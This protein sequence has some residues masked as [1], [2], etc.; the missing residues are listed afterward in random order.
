[1]KQHQNYLIRKN[2]HLEDIELW[3]E[4]FPNFL[5]QRISGENIS[6]EAKER[7]VQRLLQRA[8]LLQDTIK[9][10]LKFQQSL[11]RVKTIL[12]QKLETA[13]QIGTFRVTDKGLAVAKQEG[14]VCIDHIG[15]AVKLVDRLEF[16]RNNWLRRGEENE[17]MTA[18]VNTPSP[19][20]QG[21]FMGGET[22]M[23]GKDENNSSY[24]GN[25]TGQFTDSTGT[26]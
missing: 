17:E 1:M 19:M 2:I 21:S 3:L 24:L 23:A 15:N 12:I 9:K 4:S 18:V 8:R 13:K 6:N 25:P 10:I 11:V 22:G 14:F 7:K 16:S 5:Q 20:Q 26:L